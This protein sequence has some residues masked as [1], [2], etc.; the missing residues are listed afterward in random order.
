MDASVLRLLCVCD[1]SHGSCLCPRAACT[2]EGMAAHEPGPWGR[3]PLAFRRRV[4]FLS[5]TRGSEGILACVRFRSLGGSPWGR[6]MVQLSPL[7]AGLPRPETWG[8]RWTQRQ[9][10]DKQGSLSIR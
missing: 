6:P 7:E 4:G 3:L 10:K 8:S 2:W 1:Q 9:T 5:R